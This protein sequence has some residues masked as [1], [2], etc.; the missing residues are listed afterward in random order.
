MKA[1]RYLRPASVEEA[2]K[3]STPETAMLKAG[4]MDLLDLMK[5][6]VLT[7]DDVVQVPAVPERVRRVMTGPDGMLLVGALVT[8]AE[9]AEAMAGPLPEVAHAASLAASPQ[10]RHR[11]TVG[12]NLCQHTRCGYFRLLSMPCWKRGDKECPVLQEG[13]VQENAGIFSNGSCACAHPAS[14]PPV[15]AALDS[16]VM[17]QGAKLERT[18]PI[19]DLYA[20]PKRGKLTDTTLAAG[21]VLTRVLI[22]PQ[23]DAQLGYS[24]IRQKEAFDWPL[25]SA[26]AR[27]VL[28]GGK[29]AAANIW[30]G[31]VAPTPHRAV[32]AEKALM[33]KPF[34]DATI[35]MAAAAVADGATPL[36]GNS[37]KAELATVAVKRALLRAAGRTK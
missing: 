18:I 20:P 10:I 11:A 30:L 23:G 9:L 34:D 37:Y 5:E 28:R 1:F 21:E 15:F 6:R 14:L 27:V 26:A 22:P 33:G 29:I 32:A 17:I 16:L 2:V 13:G 31:S 7:P 8:L 19:A 4:G 36:P 12:G 3:T 35:Q 25:V 24:E